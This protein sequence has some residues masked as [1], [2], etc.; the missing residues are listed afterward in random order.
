[1]T[2]KA[3]ERSSRLPP[4]FQKRGGGHCLAFNRPD[5]LYPDLWGRASVQN[6]EGMTPALQSPAGP[7]LSGSRQW[8]HHPS[9]S[10]GQNI[11]PGRIIFKP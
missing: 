6:H 7:L 9:E 1:M 5:S 2:L 4:P 11:G 10:K 3:I 8:D